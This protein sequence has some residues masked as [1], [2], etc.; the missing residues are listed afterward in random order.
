MRLPWCRCNNSVLWRL[1]LAAV[2]DTR[3]QALV[4]WA[5]SIIGDTP[6]WTPAS[7][8]ASF[9]RY[10]RGVVGQRSWI[11]M[12]A[13]PERE[14]NAAF[15]HVAG[16]L[17]D[18]GLNAP[19]V[20]AQDTERGF[21]LLEDLGGDTYL[22]VLDD[23]N[24]EPLFD[25]AIG[26]LV[27]WQAASRPGVL[28]DYD[29][30]TLAAELEL[31]RQWYVPRH[32]RYTPTAAEHRAIDAAFTFLL[33]HIEMQPRVFVHRDYMP[34]NLMISRPLPGIIDFQDARYGPVTYDIACLFKDAFV[35]WPQARVDGWLRDYWLRAHA[36]DIP[37]AADFNTFMRQ[38]ALMGA[39]R[40][41]KVLGLF[42]RI[43]HRHGKPRYLADAPRFVSYLQ[44][45]VAQYSELKPLA[46][47]LSKQA[48]T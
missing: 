2:I 37:V 44:P 27:D 15:V 13:P 10:F 38:V 26:A 1:P 5:D 14:N 33:D 20:L 36:A 17:A 11:A 47:L 34:R 28:P 25:A 19:R 4:H 41:L 3:R 24:A 22:D 43:A 29:R 40:H 31:F 48:P 30:A 8:D 42:V 21:L 35:S 7:T 9:R 45:V 32:L 39:Q 12:D 18:I 23:D 16:L 6:E 46:A